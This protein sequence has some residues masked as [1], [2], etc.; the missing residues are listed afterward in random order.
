MLLGLMV[1]AFALA[2]N[3]APAETS[4][5]GDS[6]TASDDA[7]P[8]YLEPDEKLRRRMNMLLRIIVLLT[9]LGTVPLLY[10]VVLLDE[11]ELTLPLVAAVAGLFAIVLLIAWANRG[12]WG[13][14][15]RVDGHTLTLRD[16][17]GRK[18]SCAI[19]E[20]RFNDMAIATRD[21]MV[22][23]G[24]ARAQIYDRAAIQEQ[25]LPQ[26]ADAQRIGP[27]GMLKLQIQLNHPQGLITVFAIIGILVFG[28]VTLAL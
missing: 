26:L 12:N 17:T 27:I 2:M 18:S 22:I 8:L 24:N 23:L 6:V 7:A 5:G 20:A 9:V 28:A 21:A 19:R 25:L 13:T 3:K 16:Y 1:R 10:I 4:A 14:S 11:A 15:I